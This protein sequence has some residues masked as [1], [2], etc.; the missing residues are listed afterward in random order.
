MPAAML[1]LGVLAI[2]GIAAALLL[3]PLA[4]SQPAG[5]EPEAALTAENARG[6]C[7]EL[8]ENPKEYLSSEQWQRRNE[9]RT[10]S[11]DMAFAAEPYE[12]ALKVRVALAIPI[13]RR[14][15]RLAMLREAATQGSPEAYYWIY[16]SHNS[17]DRHLDRPQLVTRAEAD[18]ALRMA[19]QL[20]HPSAAQTLANL[21]V[22]GGIVKRDPVAARHWAERSINNPAKDTSRGDL[23]L[24]LANLLVKSDRPEERAR[25]LDLLERTSKAGVFGAKADLAEAIRKED[26]VRARSLLEEGTAP[27]PRRRHS[28]ARGNADRG[29][30][31]PGRS[32]AR[33]VATEEHAYATGGRHA[34][35]ALS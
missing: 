9:R 23:A 2:A 18:H 3:P 1:G 14:G 15:E 17:W 32:E 19:A 8:S 22:R 35:P 7:L 34:W 10:A 31:R 28:A 5:P 24:R 13:E 27:R 11:C 20:G 33:A 26:P 29:R 16:E 21:L 6:V 12:L 4:T 25:G 30:R